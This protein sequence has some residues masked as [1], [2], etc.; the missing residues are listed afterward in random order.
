MNDPVLLAGVGMGAMLQN[1]FV[2]ALAFG[3]NGSIETFVS[4]DFGKKNYMECGKTLNRAR[5]IVTLILLPVLLM[6]FWV[7]KILIAIQQDPEMAVIARKYVVQS[8]PG[9]IMFVQFD[10][11]KRYL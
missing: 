1:V 8:M 11:T 10:S 5:V 4:Q 6:F 7:D 9:V 3:L 2:F